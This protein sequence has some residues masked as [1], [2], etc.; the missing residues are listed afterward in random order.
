MSALVN[1]NPFALLSDETDNQQDRLSVENIEASRK[2][3]HSKFSEKNW[4]DYSDEEKEDIDQEDAQDEK[5][6]E[7]IAKTYTTPTSK[8]VIEHDVRIYDKTTGSVTVKKNFRNLNVVSKSSYENLKK[9]ISKFKTHV[10]GVNYNEQKDKIK[11][12]NQLLTW[13]YRDPK[14]PNC[15]VYPVAI[16][17]VSHGKTITRNEVKIGSTAHFTIS[18]ITYFVNDKADG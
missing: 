11:F 4:A 17:E 2:P 6:V 1:T 18:D 3:I 14:I 12:A 16:I 9:L 10:K 7:K 8:L 15:F 5:Q 13:C